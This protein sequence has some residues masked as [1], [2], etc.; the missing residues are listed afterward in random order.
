MKKFLSVL[1]LSYAIVLAVNLA[2]NY[3]FY[4]AGNDW[5]PGIVFCLAI[6]TLG[7]AG[8]NALS[9][10]FKRFRWLQRPMLK[11]LI[12]VSLFAAY[13]ALLMITGMKCMAVLFHKYPSGQE[14]TT[15]I[16]FSV[17]FS[18]I[19]GL[20]VSGRHFLLNLR[21]SVAHNERLEQEMIQSRFEVLKSQV[22]PHFLFNSLNTLTVM[23]PAQP[24][25][26]VQFVEQ[27]ARVFRYSLQH[28]DEQQVDVATEL[29]V[30][31]S[32]LFLNEQRFEG[33]LLVTINID[34]QAQQRNIITLSLLM[35]V[36]N[37]IK[38][39]EISTPN[40]LKIN[41]FN[42]ND[43]LVVSNILQQRI[44]PGPSTKVGL[45]NIKKRYALTTA[46]PVQI[47][48]DHNCFTVKIP[49]L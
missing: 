18:M 33:K 11:L 4:A 38:H 36:E 28:S 47:D 19:I 26:A 42:E 3:G 20:I 40:P 13:G 21:K 35:L 10:V 41:I 1:L 6:T 8:G 12:S 27:M 15:N 46:T 17:L 44:V 22:N 32:F 23:I 30:V 29:K 43:Y 34:E 24:D 9:A 25:I 48:N 7:V 16:I 39:N 37:A 2:A 5:R 14:Y 49:L 31:R 45:D